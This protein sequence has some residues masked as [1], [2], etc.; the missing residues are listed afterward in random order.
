MKTAKLDRLRGRRT[1]SMNNEAS[2][3]QSGIRGVTAHRYPD[4]VAEWN[5]PFSTVQARSQ[6]NSQLTTDKDTTNCGHTRQARIT[7]VRSILRAIA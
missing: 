1:R 2:P 6:A 7:A 4:A 3:E 5:A